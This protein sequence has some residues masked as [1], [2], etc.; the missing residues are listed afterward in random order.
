MTAAIDQA[1]GL[2]RV[3]EQRPGPQA[4]RLIRFFG[5]NPVIARKLPESTP[6]QL[7]APQRPC[8]KG[9]NCSCLQ[10][11][12]GDRHRG[13]LTQEDLCERR[14]GRR[15]RIEH[16]E[17]TLGVIKALRLISTKIPPGVNC[18]VD[19]EQ[20]TANGHQGQFAGGQVCGRGSSLKSSAML[21]IGPRLR[22]DR[23]DFTRL[24]H[25]NC[26]LIPEILIRAEKEGQNR[27]HRFRIQGG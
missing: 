9:R 10:V 20:V 26:S 6:S 27:K 5:G 19:P 14:L 12:L 4:R 23:L 2:L 13:Q 11:H 16:A 18:S 3:Q 17:H 8:M 24:E 7:N 25:L 22:K 15:R 21:Q 1:V